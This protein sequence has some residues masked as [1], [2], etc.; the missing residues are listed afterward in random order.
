MARRY[1]RVVPM[2]DVPR[3]LLAAL[4]RRAVAREAARIHHLWE[5]NTLDSLQGLAFIALGFIFQTIGTLITQMVATP[6]VGP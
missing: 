2:I 1:V 3:L 6:A 5:E 4:T